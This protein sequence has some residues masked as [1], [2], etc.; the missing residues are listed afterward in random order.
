M[1]LLDNWRSVVRYAWSFKLTLLAG[2]ISS[3][4]A[5]VQ[6]Y[7]TGNPPLVSIG[8][9]LLSFGAL[10]ARVIAQPELSGSDPWAV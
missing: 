8:A 7:L 6:Y 1:R 5:G 2:V 10:I 4:D 3:L 9:A